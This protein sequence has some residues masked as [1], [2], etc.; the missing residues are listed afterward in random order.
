MFSWFFREA[1]HSQ[2]CLGLTPGFVFRDHYWQCLGDHIWCWGLNPTQAYLLY[3]LSLHRLI[4]SGW[5]F[6]FKFRTFQDYSETGLFSQK[7]GC[8]LAS[9]VIPNDTPVFMYTN[10]WGQRDSS[11]SQAHSEH[12]GGLSLV[13]GT[14]QASAE[15]HGSESQAQSWEELLRTLSVVQINVYFPVPSFTQK[16]PLFVSCAYLGAHTRW[17]SGFIPV[18]VIRSDP[19]WC[20]ED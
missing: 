5:L 7:E 11:A 4:S 15:H 6:P 13:L 8:T 2:K 19:W 14:L 17:C 12:T 3:C 18:S 10:V 9:K 16:S 20:L 1:G